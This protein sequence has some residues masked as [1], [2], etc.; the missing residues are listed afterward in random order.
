MSQQMPAQQPM[1]MGPV[2]FEGGSQMC[3]PPQQPPMQ[4]QRGPHQ[5]QPQPPPTVTAGPQQANFDQKMS[6]LLERQ[7]TIKAVMNDPANQHQFQQLQTQLAQNTQEIKGLKQRQSMFYQQQSNFASP[8]GPPG[9]PM[10]NP[11]PG[12]NTFVDMNAP[13]AYQHPTVQAGPPGPAMQPAMINKSQSVAAWQHQNYMIDSGINSGHSTAPPSLCSNGTGNELL[14]NDDVDSVY[15]SHA[16]WSG[17]TPG[18]PQAC[19]TPEQYDSFSGTTRGVGMYYENGP[20][21]IPC[22]TPSYP[23]PQ[24]YDPNNQ[25]PPNMVVQPG[26]SQSMAPQGMQQQG[27]QPPQQQMPRQSLKEAI[28]QIAQML[29]DN[30]MVVQLQAAETAQAMAKNA[31]N[32]PA[33]IQS[34]QMIQSLVNA[35]NSSNEDIVRCAAGTLHDLSQMKPGLLSIF[36]CGGIQ[37]LIGLLQ[38]PREAILFYAI[39][40]LHNLLLHQDGAK[41]AVALANG[42]PILVR[43]LQRHSNVKFLAI[44][45]DCLRVSISGHSFKWVGESFNFMSCFVSVSC[46]RKPEQQGGNIES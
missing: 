24:Q 19:Y 43:L 37:I 39:T 31:A 2:P 11:H 8:G 36:K 20:N 46:I 16:S 44:T 45:V 34:P 15:S 5:M 10:M 12:S 22:E 9:G 41:S 30:D 35:L 13:H 6:M 25:A 23:S 17:S 7:E 21:S 29:D 4:M 18:Y 27:Q 33:I 38:S 28:S 32:R 3:M 14:D 1:Q 40:T 42:I 26:P